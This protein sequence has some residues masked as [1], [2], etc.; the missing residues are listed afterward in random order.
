MKKTLTFIIA[1]L[2]ASSMNAQILY[3]ITGKDAKN[4]SYIIGTYHL[5]DASFTE[6][7][8]EL[9]TALA[10]TEQVYGEVN[11]ENMMQPA[12]IQK[13][14]AAMM[15]PEGQTLKT[16][17]TPEQFGKVS[18]FAKEL[19]GVGLDNDM[20]FSQLGKMS[21]KALATQFTLLLFIKNSATPFNPAN[22]LDNFFQMQAKQNNKPIGGLETIDFQ[23]ETLYKSTPIERQVEELICLVDNK[24]YNLM[25]VQEISKAFY[26]QDLQA[27]EKAADEKLNNSCDS[28]PE[29]EETLIYGRNDNWMKLMPAI[30]AEK[31]TFFAVGALHLV[32]ERG[33]LAQLQKAGYTVTPCK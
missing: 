2:A 18:A 7:I 14:T 31:P 23:I 28:T 20:V 3:K 29:E 6:K 17:L 33:M 5:A 19:M 21:P 4:A 22:G 13:M 16:V 32:G 24:E 1:L 25:M 10:E 12:S 30:M 15:L 9:Q 26:A 27:I 8:P 11:M